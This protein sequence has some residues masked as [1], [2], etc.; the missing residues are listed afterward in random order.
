MPRQE[1]TETVSIL[2][3]NGIK[4]RTVLSAGAALILGMVVR[5][6]RAGAQG[7]LRIGVIG[8]GHIGSTVGTLW[9][10][11]GHPVLFSSR[12]PNE[13]R[14]FVAGLGELAK[15]GTVE[16]AIAFGDVLFVAVPYGALPEIG[17]DYGAAMK[18]KIVLDACNA[19]ARRDGVA[20]VTEVE[21]NGI[22]LVSQ[23]YLAGTR[24]VRAFNTLNYK[25]LASEANR[26]PPKLAIPIAGDDDEAVQTAAGLVRD[27]GF[28][29]VVVGKLA[30]ARS[31]QQGGPGYG[32]QVSAAELK[33][34]LSLP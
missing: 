20:I 11:A 7:K 27:A 8:S 2:R 34:K 16:Q 17:R 26:S 13:L 9:V 14:E 23:K 24:L 5:P 12:H 22:G 33:R 28:D 19:I 32:Q 18:G 6:L 10:K 1:S 29:P 4:R 3:E 15:A 21:R 30:D 25:V 31:F